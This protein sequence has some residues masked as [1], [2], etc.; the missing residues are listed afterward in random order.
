MRMASMHWSRS[1][2]P[3]RRMGLWCMGALLLLLA[4]GAGAAG[5]Y[6]CAQPDGRVVFSDH[7]CTDGQTGGALKG[8][9]GPTTAVDSVRQKA[10]RDRVHQGL[11]PECQRLGDAASR[12]Q[13]ADSNASLDTVK[14]AVSAFEDQCGDQLVA[15]S[16][17]E[18]ARNPGVRAAVLDASACQ[19]LRQTL[20]ADRARLG[21]MTHAE[22]M[23]FATQQ[24]EVSLACR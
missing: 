2:W 7:A 14:R 21:R 16:R 11:S 23:A 5:V 20:D 19:K 9:A 15:V 6:K 17:K 18:N 3:A 12:V 22:R 1:L 8:V 13:Q 24:N 4:T 10:T